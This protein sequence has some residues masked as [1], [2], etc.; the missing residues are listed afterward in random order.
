MELEVSMGGGKIASDLPRATHLILL[1]IHGLDINTDLALRRWLVVE[2]CS[3]TFHH[4]FTA[5]W[6]PLSDIIK[7]LLIQFCYV[8]P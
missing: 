7:I 8:A 2:Y 3:T 1:T 4:A 5:S 6:A